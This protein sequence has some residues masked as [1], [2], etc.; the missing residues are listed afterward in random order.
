MK[1]PVAR[2]RTRLPNRKSRVTLAEVA[3]L[4]D[5]SEITV[6]RALRDDGQVTQETRAKVKAAADLIGYVPNRIAG[7]LASARSNVIGVIMPSFSNIVFPEVLRGIHAAVEGSSFQPVVG[8]TD[9][10]INIEETLVRSLLS[11]KPAA[12]ILAGFDHTDATRQ[13]L[14]RS[15]IR[16]AELMDTGAEPID[17]AVGFSHRRAGFDIGRHL[18]ARGYR[19]FGYVGHD[20]S[21]DRRARLRYDGIVE[22][23]AASGLTLKGKALAEGPSSTAAGREM[24]AR[25]LETS[26]NIDVAV[27][28]NDDMALGG[29]FHCLKAG[30]A[31]PET[32]AIFGFNG[33]EIG[34][35]LPKRLSTLRSNRFLIGK[36]AVE[37]ILQSLDERLGPMVIDTGYE[38]VIG[39]TA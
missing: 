24:T 1:R 18:I 33:L 38:I 10:N 28:S 5:V 23:L 20:W 3:K 4:S 35:A 36:T 34:D 25:L 37:T 29:V 16:I 8:I 12:M 32:L 39:E 9:Y 2:E 15:G 11:W 6:S 14:K 17:I 7:S 19:H 13:M 30:V 31:V 26:P 27:F 22:A 21:A